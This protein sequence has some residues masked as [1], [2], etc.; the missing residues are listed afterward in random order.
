MN[1]ILHIFFRKKEIVTSLRLIKCYYTCFFVVFLFEGDVPTTPY[2]HLRSHAMLADE[3][4]LC[5]DFRE[6]ILGQ[7]F[8]VQTPQNIIELLNY[9]VYSFFPKLSNFLM[10]FD[11]GNWNEDNV[12]SVCKV[13]VL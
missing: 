5:F 13:I 7:N 11:Y 6:K 9:S 1:I 12:L 3:D 4:N 2:N 10:N 8:F